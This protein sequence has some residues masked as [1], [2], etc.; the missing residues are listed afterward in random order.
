MVTTPGNHKGLPQRSFM[1]TTPGNHKGL[2]LHPGDNSGQP[3]GIAH[4]SFYGDNSG[5]PQGIAPT[6]W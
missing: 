3:Q 4:T 1:V 6:S 2:P 5:Q